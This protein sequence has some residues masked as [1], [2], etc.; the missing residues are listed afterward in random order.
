MKKHAISA[1]LI[2]LVAMAAVPAMASAITLTSAGGETL[3]TGAELNAF[4]SN[5]VFTGSSG[6]QLKCTENTF[7][8]ELQSGPG[9]S[10]T[11]AINSTSFTGPE[12][13]ACPTNVEGVTAHVSAVESTLPWILH[14]SSGD[15]WS[16]THPEFT[17]TITQAGTSVG[18]CTFTAA[19]VSGTYTTSPAT[20]TFTVGTGN[21]TQVEPSSECTSA[22]GTLAG[23][24][25]AS[26]GGG[27]V[28]AD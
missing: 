10:V 7:E 28:K 12:G 25:A 26:S 22:T 24:A 9:S 21:F 27:P 1:A 13:S 4:S 2:A 11:A 19:E 18:H 17:A 3:K 16:L 8:G 23:S 6:L 15:K 20:L 5:L 14:F